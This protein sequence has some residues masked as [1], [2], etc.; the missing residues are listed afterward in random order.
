MHTKRLP[1]TPRNATIDH[2]VSWNTIAPRGCWRYSGK[3]GAVAF[4]DDMLAV[5]LMCKACIIVLVFYLR[6]KQHFEQNGDNNVILFTPETTEHFTSVNFVSD[7]NLPCCG[8]KNISDDF[9]G[10]VTR[11]MGPDGIQS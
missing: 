4:A 11:V 10:S 6:E 1:I 9:F 3:P 8:K 7:F 2:K 5:L